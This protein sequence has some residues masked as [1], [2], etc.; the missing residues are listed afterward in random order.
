IG[1]LA[2]PYVAEMFPTRPQLVSPRIKGLLQ[3]ASR[4]I[5]PFS[6]ARQTLARPRTE[7]LSIVPRHV[8]Y[9]MVL[10]IL[11]VGLR[12]FRC[13]PARSAYLAP[14][15]SR[16]HRVLDE[17]LKSLGRN[18]CPENERPAELFRFCPIPCVGDKLSEDLVGDRISIDRKLVQ[19]DRANRAFSV[20]RKTPCIISSHQ[21]R[22]AGESHHLC[23]NLRTHGSA[24]RGYTP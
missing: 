5:L 8:H 15:R 2:L 14:P 23:R 13:V 6:F 10:A 16:R 20:L 11:Q 21:E 19:S 1:T 12:S 18:V 22:A 4:R 9:R 3:A 24:G 7:R 17:F